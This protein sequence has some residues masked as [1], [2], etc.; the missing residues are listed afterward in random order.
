MAVM[1]DLKKLWRKD[2]TDDERTVFRCFAKAG[3]C[4]ELLCLVD[5]CT[6]RG[7]NGRKIALAATDLLA[8]LTWPIDVQKELTDMLEDAETVITDYASL[9]R[10]QVTFKNLILR[11]GMTIRNFMILLLPSL[12]L[13]NRDRTEKDRRIISLMLHMIR[14]LLAIRDPVGTGVDVGQAMELGSLQSQLIV[15]LEESRFIPLML[16]L[17]ENADKSE[18]EEYNVLVLDA[19][20]LIYRT[21]EVED[22]VQPSNEAS[23]SGALSKLLE[24]EERGKQ[25]SKRTVTSRHSRFGTTLSIYNGKQRYI[26][27]KQS[28]ITTSAGQVI[29]GIKKKRAGQALQ[30]NQLTVK[31][32]GNTPLSKEA[33]QIVK[34]FAGQFLLAFDN[35]F[36]S[37]LKDIRMG[38]SK[39]RETDNVRV[40]YLCRF[41]MEYFMTLRKQEKGAKA[42]KQREKEMAKRQA[43]KARDPLA[44]AMDFDDDSFLAELEGRGDGDKKED[45]EEPEE[46]ML[47]FRLLAEIFQ[48][49]TRGWLAK[50]LDEAKEAKPRADLEIQACLDFFTQLLEVIAE[51]AGDE[52]EE[53]AELSDTLSAK[54][55]HSADFID[56][57]YDCLRTYK[58]QSM[59]YLDSAI[60]FTYTLIKTLERYSKDKGSIHTR[61]K[62]DMKRRKE[63]REAAGQEFHDEDEQAAALEKE[64]DTYLEQSKQFQY[65]ERRLADDRIVS[66]LIRYLGR[67]REMHDVHRLKRLVS[68]IHR[69][70]VSCQSETVFFKVSTCNPDETPVER[71]A[72]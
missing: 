13:A 28:S 48:D 52:D 20:W 14:N 3:L 21:V 55:L 62:R 47:D 58:N 18:F 63:A 64:K 12:A 19:L 41:F 36:H 59:A 68:L 57:A 31:P 8:A 72:R 71:G 1:R 25:Q 67:Y 37:I 49:D 56:I 38:R 61:K 24:E 26:L 51:M 43:A 15:Q 29:D 33:L 5:E 27:H 2:D 65:Y 45:E 22:L 4:I 16:T 10:H 42:K 46:S 40:L 6:G 70:V 66:T 34:D 50:R 69:I 23:S 39:I 11:S 60:N 54:L 17:A 35:F 44:A 53:I 9:L 32:T 30:R 7:E